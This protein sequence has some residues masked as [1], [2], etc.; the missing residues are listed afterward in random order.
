MNELS[1]TVEVEG[2]KRMLKKLDS[3]H[4]KV[5]RKVL[6]PAVTKTSRLI[7]KGVKK[8]ITKRTGKLRKSINPKIIIKGNRAT[9]LIGAKTGTPYFHL[10]VKGTA[11]RKTKKGAN[12]GRMPAKDVLDE[13][14]KEG[15]PHFKRFL[16]EAFDKYVK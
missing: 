4:Y 16:K 13:A 3:V 15:A 12:R 10:F 1:V 6:R 14:V 2:I 11:V 8:R 5:R 7:V 9:G